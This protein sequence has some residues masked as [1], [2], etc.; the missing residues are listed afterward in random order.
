MKSAILSVADKRGL[1]EIA[2]GLI[3]L[4]YC[5]YATDATYR[6]LRQA[7]LP[8]IEV[9]ELTGFPEILEGRVKTLHPMVFGGIL[10]DRSNLDHQ[11]DVQRHRLPN[12]QVVVVN[13]Y[14]FGMNPGVGNIDIGGHALLRSAAKNHASVVP[15]FD[16]AEYG[17]ILRHLTAGDLTLSDRQAIASDAFKHCAAYDDLVARWLAEQ[18]LE[19]DLAATRT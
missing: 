5:L 17:Y 6:H 16:P 4:G 9:A 12:I 19:A 15:V 10:A 14:R 13:L 1:E 11:L 2:A 7:S 3:G 18:S 8:A